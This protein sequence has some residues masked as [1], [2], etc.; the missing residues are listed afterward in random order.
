MTSKPGFD[1]RDRDRGDTS[2]QRSAECARSVA[3]DDQ[4]VWRLVQLRQDR[5]GDALDV[6]VRVGS[7]RAVQPGRRVRAQPMVGGVE[8]DVLAGQ[9]QAGPHV[10]SRKRSGDGG[11]LDRFGSGADD[12]PDIRGS[13][14]SPSF[15]RINLRP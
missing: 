3:L 9:D 2:G 11:K 7:P 10:A 8:I 1:M 6:L 15:G 12:E 5:R 13:Q 14:T 4:Q